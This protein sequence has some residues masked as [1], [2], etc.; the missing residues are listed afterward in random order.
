MDLYTGLKQARATF[1][2]DRPDES[3]RYVSLEHAAKVV[4]GQLGDQDFWELLR[5]AHGDVP[6]VQLRQVLAKVLCDHLSADK[7]LAA[8]DALRYDRS[9]H[10]APYIQPVTHE[11]VWRPR[12]APEPQPHTR[13]VA[14]STAEVAERLA[15]RK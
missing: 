2:E 10:L 1:E 11:K 15:R 7:D 6:S 5:E 13:H 14:T 3:I 4:V 12:P 9:R 8:E